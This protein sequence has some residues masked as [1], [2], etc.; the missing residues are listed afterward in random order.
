MDLWPIA[1]PAVVLMSIWTVLKGWR[2]QKMPQRLP[3]VAS[4]A[5][6][7]YWYWEAV[8]V[9]PGDNIRA[10]LVLFYPILL[11]LTIAALVSLYRTW[12]RR[13]IPSPPP[14]PSTVS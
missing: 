1:V 4:L 9:S 2:N 10:D 6:L 12:G 5:W 8:V 3:V 11:G 7:G 13:L 14:P